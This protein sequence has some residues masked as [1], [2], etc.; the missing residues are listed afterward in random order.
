[1]TPRTR[2]AKQIVVATVNISNETLRQPS[3]STDGTVPPSDSSAEPEVVYL[4]KLLASRTRERDEVIQ[5]EI[6]TRKAFDSERQE[7]RRELAD[8]RR[9]SE[10]QSAYQRECS[11]LKKQMSQVQAESERMLTELRKER[12]EAVRSL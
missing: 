4:A 9:Q 12:A 6:Q 1:M 7:L 11:E 5:K 3:P 2:I 8:L 10:E